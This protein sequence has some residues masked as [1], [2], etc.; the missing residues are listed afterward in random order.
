MA[1]IVNIVR[2]PGMALRMRTAAPR[3]LTKWAKRQVKVL[4]EAYAAGGHQRHGGLRWKGK[5][6]PGPLLIG[7]G[8]MRRRTKATVKGTR[9][10]LGNDT[11]Y[12]IFHDEGTK[13]LPKRTLI[14]VTSNDNRLLHGQ[15]RIGLERSLR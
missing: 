12:A 14:V 4:K 3:I 7:S 8:T 9:V 1:V 11:P 6:E 15:L 13:E 5:S 10:I 2:V